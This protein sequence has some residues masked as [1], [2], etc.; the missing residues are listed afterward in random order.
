MIDR[1]RP[2]YQ[3]DHSVRSPITEIGLPTSS[4]HL[5]LQHS[6]ILPTCTRLLSL[7]LAMLYILAFYTGLLAGRVDDVDKLG[8]EGRASDEE[9]VNIGL[10]G[11]K[12]E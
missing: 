4:S 7:P 3:S 5:V 9:A 11:Y 12:R 6:I 1:V 8:L 10:S 2:V